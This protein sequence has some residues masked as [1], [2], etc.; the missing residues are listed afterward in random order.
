MGGSAKPR[1]NSAS[2]G[3]GVGGEEEM[4]NNAGP[5]RPERGSFGDSIGIQAADAEKGTVIWLQISRILAGPM[6]L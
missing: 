1:K 4:G 2:G 5:G 6:G 3:F